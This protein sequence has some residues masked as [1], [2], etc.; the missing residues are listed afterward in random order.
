MKVN[1]ILQSGNIQQL[2]NDNLKKKEK[3]GKTISDKVEI[4]SESRSKQVNENLK[5]KATSEVKKRIDV[6]NEKI[7]E[8][9]KKIEENYY[10]SREIMEQVAESLIRNLQL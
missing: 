5:T 9:K 3:A 6:R 10:E 4:S 2:K 8:I 1:G 7:T